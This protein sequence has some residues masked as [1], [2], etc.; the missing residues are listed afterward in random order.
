MD[1]SHNTEPLVS[2]AVEPGAP[3]AAIGAQDIQAL[4]AKVAEKSQFVDA[5]R[6]GWGEEPL[7]NRE[8]Y[9]AG[10]WGPEAAEDLLAQDGHVWHNPQPAK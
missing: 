9:A 1:L 7:S 8:F 2:D 4:N 6:A 3:P 5:I 10:T